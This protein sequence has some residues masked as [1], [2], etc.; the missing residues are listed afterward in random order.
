M[1]NTTPNK[2]SELLTTCQDLAVREAEIG[3]DLGVAQNK[4]P[5]ILVDVDDLIGKRAGYEIAKDQLATYRDA[6]RTVFNTGRKYMSLNREVLKPRL[7]NE[8]SD[9]WKLAGFEDSFALPDSPAQMQQSV[10]TLQK[11][12]AANPTAEVAALNLTAVAAQTLFDQIS[13]ARGALYNQEMVV[14]AAKEARDASADNL[15]RRYRGFL[16]ELSQ[17]IGPLDVRWKAFGLNIPGAPATPDV[18]EGL[19]ATLIGPTA[20]R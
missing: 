18:V 6:L 3:D 9:T 16:A 7:G 11:Y 15:R 8:Y 20:W 2:D 14:A 13:N 10:Q 4:A 5:K 19:K 12:F 17:L 1:T